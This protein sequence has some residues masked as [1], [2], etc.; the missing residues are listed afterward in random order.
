MW[1]NAPAETSRTI[2]VPRT[3]A[4][5]ETVRFVL[6]RVTM[7]TLQLPLHFP[8][9]PCRAVDSSFFAAAPRIVRHTVE[10]DASPARVF[11]ILEDESSWPK[12]FTGLLSVEWLSAPG[13]GAERKVVLPLTT[14]NEL[15]FRWEPS[16]RMSFRFTRM[17]APVFNALAEDYLLELLPNSRTR[18]VYTVAYEPGPLFRLAEPVTRWAFG[19]MCKNA[20]EN[21][22]GYVRKHAAEPGARSFIDSPAPTRAG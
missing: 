5:A 19:A 2:V 16:R 17:S 12:W 9:F 18:F 6:S 20:S 8:T 22:V 10:L 21:L 14:A 4:F 11:A 3:Y 1:A 13:L 15:F 7:T